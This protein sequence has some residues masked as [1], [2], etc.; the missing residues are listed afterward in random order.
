[1]NKFLLLKPDDFQDLVSMDESIDAAEQGY[2]DGMNFPVI[3]APRRRVH[4]PAGVHISKFRGGAHSMGVIGAA[5]RADQ[6]VK[7]K[8]EANQ[9]YAY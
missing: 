9:H 3:N 1:M 2:I 6:V 7:E 8:G 4:S 5:S